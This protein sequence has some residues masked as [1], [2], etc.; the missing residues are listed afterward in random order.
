M[1]K[2]VILLMACYV[3]LAFFACGSGGNRTNHANENNHTYN[4][5]ATTNENDMDGCIR[6]T[7]IV[8]SVFI[9][10]SAPSHQ[11]YINN[12]IYAMN[13]SQGNESYNFI[14]DLNI[15]PPNPD[16]VDLE[17]HWQRLIVDF[18][19]GRKPDMI[20]FQNNDIRTL[21]N[22]GFLVDIYDFIEQ[23]PN[24][25]RDDFFTSV[26]SAFEIQ[27]GLYVFPL[28]FGFEYVGINA[29]LPQHFIDRFAQLSYITIWQMIEIYMELMEGYWDSF[30]HMD[31]GLPAAWT[32]RS[33]YLPVNEANKLFANDILLMSVLAEHIDFYN[34]RVDLN[35]Q[36]FI[37]KLGVIYQT[38]NMQNRIVGGIR[39]MGTASDN[40]FELI[41]NHNIFNVSSLYLQPMEAF[42]TPQ[43][44]HYINYIPLANEHGSLI[45]NPSVFMSNTQIFDPVVAQLGIVNTQN[46]MYAWE[47]TQH[48][49]YEY[50]KFRRGS[51][52]VGIRTPILRSYFPNMTYYNILRAL[53]RDM[54][55]IHLSSPDEDER[56][57][58]AQNAVA[59]IAIYNEM[60][61]TLLTDR[62][63]S[64]L[65]QYNM[66]LFFDG[67]IPAEEF[68]QR[69]HNAISLWL[70]E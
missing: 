45:I 23:C 17:N 12:A 65:F 49:I 35:N 1:I 58:I 60:P 53:G 5:A 30:G 68:A 29:H 20:L 46:M 8:L 18:M 16:F 10:N 39:A 41:A 66:G 4:H 21:I 59:R 48:M 69:T 62:I 26:L 9:A 38:I 14:L 19:T 67:I 64:D 2:F 51:A 34:G 25:N 61:I 57:Q 40:I 31:I 24:T 15:T 7:E 52:S 55:M 42:I 28:S 13:N 11:V 56:S 37:N 47:L 63:P 32:C 33:W 6:A 22:H 36:R 50:N 70:I 43:S 54:Y 27:G 3:S 44:P